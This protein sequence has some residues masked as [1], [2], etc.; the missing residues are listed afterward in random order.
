M[1]GFNKKKHFFA[2]NVENLAKRNVEPTMDQKSV[3]KKNLYFMSG[4]H[5][6]THFSARNG[7]ILAKRFF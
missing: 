5:A 3:I 4:F 7:K 2:T 1:I 6:K